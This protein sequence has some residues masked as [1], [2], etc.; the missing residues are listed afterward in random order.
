MREKIRILTWFKNQRLWKKILYAFILSSTIP[1]LVVQG[2]MMHINSNNL[3]TKIDELMKSQLVQISE[4]MNLTLEIYTNLV[5]QI[6]TDEIIIEDMKAIMEGTQ[7]EQA[8]I[9]REMYSRIQQYGT[10]VEGIAGIT[11]IMSDGESISYD[12]KSASILQSIWDDEG[13]LRNIDPYRSAQESNGIM[14]SPTNRYVMNGKEE[15]FFHMS[16]RIHDFKS[17]DAKEVGTV[18]VSIEEDVLSKVCGTGIDTVSGK[19]YSVNFI[20]DY[21]NNLMCY[22]D[23]FYSGVAMDSKRSTEEFVKITGRLKDRSLAVN[24]Y[25]DKELGWTYYNVYDVN[26]MFQD[27]AKNQRVTIALGL[28]IMGV[29]IL[30]ILYTVWLIN[31]STRLILKG[32][33]SVQDGDYDTK[34]EMETKDEF[35]QIANSFNRMTDKVKASIV[36]V[37][38]ATNKKKEAE[39]RALEAQINPHFLYNTLDSINWMAIDKGEYEIS[40][41]LRNLGVILRYSINKSNQKVTVLE[42]VDWLEKY[43]SLQQMRFNESFKFELNVDSAAEH[44][45]IFKLMIQPFI[46]N[47]I[48]HGFRGVTSG[49]ILRVDIRLGNEEELWIIIEDNGKGMEETEVKKYNNPDIQDDGRSIGLSNSFSRMKMYYGD[50]VTWN[51]SSIQ[52]MGTIITLKI[53]IDKEI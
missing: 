13:D 5:Y 39:I 8:I 14:I 22:P 15:R 45:K 12:F 9:T 32:I 16:K 40:K 41:M 6:Y 26:Y 29:A 18:V 20:A 52:G 30:M 42:S 33:G 4:R 51:I 44:K 36:E 50:K 43:V 1:L 17:I 24:T 11:I 35:G 19:E 47:A 49:G 28:L 48:V 25:V 27:L 38:E 3:K 2:V 31:Q 37:K 53:P 46:E 21:Q 10:S 23:S 7:E 34:I